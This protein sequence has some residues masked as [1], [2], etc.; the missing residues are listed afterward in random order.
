[1]PVI[2]LAMGIVPAYL[3][4]KKAATLTFERKGR[5]VVNVFMNGKEPFSVHFL[6][7]SFLV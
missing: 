7:S 5:W 2:D 3:H 6:E 1:M 4:V